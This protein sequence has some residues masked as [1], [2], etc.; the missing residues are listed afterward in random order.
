MYCVCMISAPW[1]CHPSV[2][3]GVPCEVDHYHSLFPLEA[4]DTTP[5]DRQ[6][7]RTFGYAST[8]Y[9]AIDARDGLLYVIRRIHG[10]R[11]HLGAGH[12]GGGRKGSR[13]GA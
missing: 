1:Q 12:I 8:C 11:G 7:Q 6:G 5:P 13:G 4:I 9:K 2:P 10:R 3:E